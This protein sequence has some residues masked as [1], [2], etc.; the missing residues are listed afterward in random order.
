MQN[1]FV[2][3]KK[4]LFG[5]DWPCIIKKNI[6]AVNALDLDSCRKELVFTPV[7][8]PTKTPEDKFLYRFLCNP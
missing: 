4:V 3:Y 7:H 6:D 2:W 5:T 8:H 1:S